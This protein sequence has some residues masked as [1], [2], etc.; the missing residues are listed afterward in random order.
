MYGSPVR[1]LAVPD[2]FRGTLTSTQAAD[3]IAA[4]WTRGR[5]DDAVEK[6][7]MADGGEGTLEALV[8]AGG[9]RVLMERASGPLGDPVEAE[10]GLIDGG[11]TAVVE[12]ARASGLELVPEERRDALRATTRGTGE[13]I[14]AAAR[15]GPDRIVVCIGG[16]A[17]TDGGAGMAQALGARLLDA[18]GRDI[19]PGGVAL[20]ELDRIDAAGIDPAVRACRFLV[21]SDV[22]NPLVG[23]LG[24]AA[25]YGPQKGA[26]AED[27]EVLDRALTH[28]A[29]VLRRD[30]GVDV[31]ERPG[32]GAAGGLGA[33][34]MAFLDAELRPG[35]DVVMEAAR[36]GERLIGAELV[37]TG[38]GKLDLQSLHGKTVA[39]VHRA[40]E[41]AGIRVLVVCGQAT[42]RPDGVRVEALADAFGLDRA[43]HDTKAALEELVEGVAARWPA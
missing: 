6:V 29:K 33:G 15:H 8:A 30:L 12:M 27:V 11:R 3:A 34:L 40:A 1:V 7:P 38:E 4:G 24:A 13:L 16:S 36:F 39:G 20:L 10:F 22:D 18:S 41:D 5:P 19:G 23:P 14:L 28:Y 17:T 25:V 31:A 21:A 42:V 35:I 9:G 37:V 43:M 2:K 26:S 32:A